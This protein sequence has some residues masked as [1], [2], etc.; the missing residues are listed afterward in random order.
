M[1][2]IF[3]WKISLPSQ[4]QM[5]THTH[6]KMQKNGNIQRRNVQLNVFTTNCTIKTNIAPG[7][8]ITKKKNNKN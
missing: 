3:Q 7:N 4:Q 1:S 5:H 6:T 8:E 2:V